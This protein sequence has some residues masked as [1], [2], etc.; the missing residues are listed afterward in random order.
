MIH[1]LNSDILIQSEHLK[2]NYLSPSYQLMLKEID[3]SIQITFQEKHKQDSILFAVYIVIL[4][5]LYF[6]V[7]KK[8]I[9]QTRHSVWVTKCMLAIIPLEIIEKVPKI[10][11]FL[12]TSSR[13]AL[14]AFKE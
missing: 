10:K 7:W 2:D 1:M 9:D 8:F 11:E 3:N 4:F 13:N 5:A 6:V 12:L 14:S